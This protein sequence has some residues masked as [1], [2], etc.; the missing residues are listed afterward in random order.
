MYA[1]IK[2]VVPRRW[3]IRFEP[4]IRSVLRLLYR[5]DRYECNVCGAGLS[6]FITTDVDRVCPACG[7][8]ARTRRLFAMLGGELRPGTA[9]L[10]FSP[11]RPLYRR[12]RAWPGIRYLATDYAGEFLADRRYD[13][14]AIDETSDTF[15][16]VICFHVLE[17]VED[18]RA[19]I[20][21]LY[22]VLKPA[23][24][25]FVQTPFKAGDIDEDA[26]VTSPDE[27]RRRFGQ[28]DHVRN[29]SVAGLVARLQE[30]GFR[31][32][33]TEHIAEPGNRSGFAEREIIVV[34]EKPVP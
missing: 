9:V 31:A 21:E 6:R 5:G 32:E 16:L 4:A 26:S 34:A 3:L 14:T 10:D 24:R 11:N 17:H 2:S 8:L 18:D 33:A 13:I 12:L 7:S 25:A 1:R 30:A 15:D 28:E 20:R 19:A 29:Y 27:R 22:R 23:G